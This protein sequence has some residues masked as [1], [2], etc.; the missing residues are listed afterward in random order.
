MNPKPPDGASQPVRVK[1]A[2]QAVTSAMSRN[3]PNL[4]GAAADVVMIGPALGQ[5]GRLDATNERPLIDLIN[6]GGV[7]CA[8]FV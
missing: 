2:M 1:L 8:C 6:W 5:H 7:T 3:T 4:I